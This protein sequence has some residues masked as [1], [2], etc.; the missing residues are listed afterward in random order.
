MRTKS[1]AAAKSRRKEACLARGSDVTEN[2][3]FI[4]L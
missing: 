1:K 3:D 4:D 2:G